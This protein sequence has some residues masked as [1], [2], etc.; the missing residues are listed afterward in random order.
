MF[1][2]VDVTC[3]EH[4]EEGELSLSV[5]VRLHGDVFVTP[6]NG[7]SHGTKRLSHL[8]DVFNSQLTAHSSKLFTAYIVF[9]DVVNLFDFNFSR[10]TVTV[11]ALRKHDVVS[12]HAFVAGDDIHIDPV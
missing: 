5:V 2:L 7:E 4:T 1:I 12:G 3:F 9:G 8:F 6:V 11:P 10:E